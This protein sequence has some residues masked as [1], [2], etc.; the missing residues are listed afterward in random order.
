MASPKRSSP[1]ADQDVAADGVT[2][3]IPQFS[4]VVIP[5]DTERNFSDYNR[6]CED[7]D[8]DFLMQPVNEADYDS[9]T[10]ACV[11]MRTGGPSNFYDHY[12]TK[13]KKK[14]GRKGP[15]EKP[16]NEPP[17]FTSNPDML[18]VPGGHNAVPKGALSNPAVRRI[19]CGAM[20]PPPSGERT[21]LAPRS[22]GT[23]QVPSPQSQP[24][25]ILNVPN[26]SVDISNS[27]PPTYT[28]HMAST[29]ETIEKEE[30]V[31][32]H[33]E[34]EE[35]DVSGN[36]AAGQDEDSSAPPRAAGS[37]DAGEQ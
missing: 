12:T 35:I 30:D 27:S 11:D 15:T 9:E 6:P 26:V 32:H 16:L 23:V 5:P 8:S 10:Q 7:L 36:D 33:R 4:I 2:L 14:R 28:S 1:S 29:A 22:W 24:Y 20:P 21:V 17:R 25:D 3:S 19:A 31:D 18:N 37:A 13:R 34:K